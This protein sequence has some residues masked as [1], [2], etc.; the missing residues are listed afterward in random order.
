MIYCNN[1]T[2]SWRKKTMKESKGWRP[3][4]DPNYTHYL[5]VCLFVCLHARSVWRHIGIWWDQTWTKC[6]SHSLKNKYAGLLVYGNN[7]KKQIK[8]KGKRRERP[9]A[10]SQQIKLINFTVS[11]WFKRLWEKVNL[12][13]DLGSTVG[14]VC[15]LHG[16]NVATLYKEHTYYSIRPYLQRINLVHISPV[17]IGHHQLKQSFEAK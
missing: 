3:K 2:F 15:L 9:C 16:S 5:F 8:V 13:L 12:L 6:S 1:I 7:R 17:I 4:R 10:H 11:L 14:V